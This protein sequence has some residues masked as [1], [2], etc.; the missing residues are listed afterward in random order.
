VRIIGDYAYVAD[1]THGVSVID[2]ANPSQPRLVSIYQTPGKTRDV[3]VVGL[4]VFAA[5]YDTG[6]RVLTWE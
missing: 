1:W 3:D 6:L 4:Y 2:V 5:D